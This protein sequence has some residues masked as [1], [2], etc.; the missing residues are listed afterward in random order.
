LELRSIG[1]HA[2]PIG[3]ARARVGERGSA[4]V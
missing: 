4:G 3:A 2:G 1:T